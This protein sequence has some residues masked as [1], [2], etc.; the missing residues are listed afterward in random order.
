MDKDAQNGVRKQN[1]ALNQWAVGKPKVAKPR[2]RRYT[3][4]QK[5]LRE[6]L[7]WDK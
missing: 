5:R 3:E 1:A 6:R 7:G 2:K 4:A